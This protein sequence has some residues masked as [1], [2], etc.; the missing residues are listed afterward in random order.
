MQTD[1]LHTKTTNLSQTGSKN[2]NTQMLK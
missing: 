2:K 1:Y